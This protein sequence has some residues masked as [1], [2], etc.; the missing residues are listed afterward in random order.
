MISFKN[1]FAQHATWADWVTDLESIEAGSPPEALRWPNT[2]RFKNMQAFDFGWYEF[3]GNRTDFDS[4]DVKI[5]EWL[6]GLNKNMSSV[7]LAEYFDEGLALLR[8]KIHIDIEELTYVRMKVNKNQVFPKESELQ[9]V[10]LLSN[11]DR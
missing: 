11:V 8:Q 6:E 7:I 1:Y 10:A 9:R 4:N 5:S 2:L 3:V